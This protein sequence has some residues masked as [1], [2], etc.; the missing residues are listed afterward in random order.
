MNMTKIPK[1]NRV[2]SGINQLQNPLN[3]NF[4]ITSDNN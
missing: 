2:Y 3:L 4:G 1:E